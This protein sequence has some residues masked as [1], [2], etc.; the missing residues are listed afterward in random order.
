MKR[1]LFN[2]SLFLFLSLPISCGSSPQSETSSPKASRGSHSG[3]QTY[4]FLSIAVNYADF[5]VQHGRDVYGR[6]QSP[7]FASAI[8]RSTMKLDPGLAAIEIAGVRERDRSLSGANVIHDTDLFRLL[9]SLSDLTGEGSYRTEALEA[10]KFF[11]ENGQSEV[12]GLMCWGEHLYWDFLNE[13][14]GFA[15]DYDFHE[16]KAWPFWEEA[17]RVAP[18]ASWSFAIGEWDH[19]IHDKQSGDFSRHARWTCHETFSGFEFPRYAGQMME[20]WAYAYER[21]ENIHQERRDE[22]L[23]AI[24][25]L[26]NRMK[27]NMRLT[28]SGYLPAGRSSQGDHK[29]LVWLTSNLELARC[30]EMSAPIMDPMVTEEMRSFA[31]KQDDDFLHAPHQLDSA[32]G[33][34]AVTLHA[35]SGLPR[36]RSMNKPYTTTWSS[37]YGYGTHAGTAIVCFQRYKA[38]KDRYPARAGAYQDLILKAAGKYLVSVPDESDLLKPAEFAAVVELMLLS[39]D[40]TGTQAFLDRALFFGRM[41]IGLFFEEGNPLPRASNRDSHYESITGG[42]DFIF[43]LL[44]VHQ[45]LR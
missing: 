32:D 3:D 35:Q 22:L 12:T 9:Y 43:Q 21:P 18:E 33:G 11:F 29:N 41:G 20:R 14:C 6:E 17:Y 42:P 25:V 34:F 38:L 36:E 23:V 26:F 28:E 2:C 7:L 31:L 15:P 39:F 13:D 45:E 44:Q 30:L 40:L 4:E 8:N 1:N 24:E 19:Q 37:G 27:E 10:L 5:M 16:T